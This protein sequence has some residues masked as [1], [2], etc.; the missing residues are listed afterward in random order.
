MA[1]PS[2]AEKM[3]SKRR[4]HLETKGI[5]MG[6]QTNFNDGWFFAKKA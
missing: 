6:K 5:S 1:A 4:H 2:A 3:L